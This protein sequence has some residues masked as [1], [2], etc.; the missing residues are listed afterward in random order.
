MPL[1]DPDVT[2]WERRI[3]QNRKSTA[4]DRLH[5]AQLYLD[6]GDYTAALELCTYIMDQE[7][8]FVPAVVEAG[9]ACFHLGFTED[10]L[11]C[12][13]TALKAPLAPPAEMLFR[14]ALCYYRLDR[15][16][17]AEKALWQL[18]NDVPDYVDPYDALIGLYEELE[19]TRRARALIRRRDEMLKKKTR[20]DER[21]MKE[22]LRS[23]RRR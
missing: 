12:Y 10:A 1:R 21:I 22:Y 19:H 20:Q 9:E 13:D 6:R 17:E 15:M 14:R 16:E 5:L 18:I 8:T 4:A 23:I 2:H 11:L 7:P 3:Q